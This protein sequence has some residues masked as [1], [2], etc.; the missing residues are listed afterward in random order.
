[1]KRY[2]EEARKALLVLVS[3]NYAHDGMT[4]LEFL[5]NRVHLYSMSSSNFRNLRH[6]GNGARGLLKDGTKL[7]NTHRGG[8]IGAEIPLEVERSGHDAR[9]TGRRGRAAK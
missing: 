8:T 3:G 5:K 9:V 4:M 1:M 7:R 6:F 2:S